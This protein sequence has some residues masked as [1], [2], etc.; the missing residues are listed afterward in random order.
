MKLIKTKTAVTSGE[1]WRPSPRFRESEN[2]FTLIEL[3]VV[4]AII[5]ILAAMLLPALSQAKEKAK[6]IYCI[7]NLKQIELAMILYK[8]DNQ[9]Y[10]AVGFDPKA[11]MWVWPSLLRRY[12]SPNGLDTK[13]FACP[14]APQKDQW[15]TTLGSGLP[16]QYGYQQD[17]FRLL[18]TGKYHMSYGHNCWGSQANIPEIGLG[19][20][21]GDPTYGFQK[22]SAVRKPTEM[23]A[24]GDSN[25]DT[26]KNGDPKYSG[27]IANY[28]ERQWPLELHNKR[29]SI[30]WVDGHATSV[31]R[32]S[33]I[34]FLVQ[35]Q[36]QGA[37][38]AACA[39]WN[40]DNQPHY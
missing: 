28:G 31:K 35:P 17:E 15:I 13:V 3:L 1:L 27:F 26:N 20:F 24:F 18:C 8:S 4:I 37:M 21:W 10:F 23:I 36:S 2:G 14:S 33:I 9:D 38:D 40:C 25:W 19:C 30:A 22:E 11:T 7:G 5:A 12:T 39:L 16:A 34:S 6:G 29:A 32:S